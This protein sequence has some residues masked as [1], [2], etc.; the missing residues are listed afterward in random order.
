MKLRIGNRESGTGNW[1]LVPYLRNRLECFKTVKSE[2]GNREPGTGNYYLI[3]VN[4]T[5]VSKV[6]IGNKEPVPGS[7]LTIIGFILVSGFFYFINM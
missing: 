3:L 2:T 4:Y 5:N 7:L 6:Q 1:F